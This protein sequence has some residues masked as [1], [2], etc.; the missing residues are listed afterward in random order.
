MK[1][2]LILAMLFSLCLPFSACAANGEANQSEEEQISSSQVRTEPVYVA[3][4]ALYRGTITEIQG[5][6]YRMEMAP[7][8]NYGEEVLLVT[9][10][11]DTPVYAIPET[12]LQTGDYIEIY[13][14]M[15]QETYPAQTTALGVNYL[16]PN[17]EDV[18][19]NGVVQSIEQEN[20]EGLAMLL[21]GDNGQ[22]A[23]F[24]T[25]G[26]TQ[27]YMDKAD[28]VP[29]AHLS[30]FFN[31][32]MTLSLPPQSTADEIAPFTYDRTEADTISLA[33]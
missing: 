22:E 17:A 20:E 18:V 29:G 14:T 19:F 1:R 3:D 15:L 28:I 23:L 13:Y 30:I 27:I 16:A 25:G 10:E 8:R 26:Q 5:N 33:E 31:G 11:Q 21:L 7:G 12:G 24:R 2:A 32:V 6:V 4:A 9:M